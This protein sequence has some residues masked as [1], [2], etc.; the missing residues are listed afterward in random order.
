[1]ALSSVLDI[2]QSGLSAFQSALNVTSNNIA[3]ADNPNYTKQ[4]VI[5]S[6][7]GSQL[8]G[9]NY[10]GLGVN[11]GSIQRAS[12][13]LI[14]QQIRTNNGVYSNF[15]TRNDLL[16]QVQNLFG[17]PSSNGLSSLTSAFF[18]AWQAL[19]VTP[20]SITLRNNVIQAAQ[21]M[22]NQIQDINNGIQTIKSSIN[23]QLLNTVNQ[24]NSD[25]QKIHDLN[26]QI[27]SAGAT[28]GQPND[29]MDNRDQVIN[30]LSNLVN[31]NVTY[32]N[33]NAASISIGGSFA[34]DGGSYNQLQ[35][36]NS[37]GKLII[38]NSNGNSTITLN[39]G[40][41]FALQDVYNNVIPSY[42]SGLDSYVN[43]L[44]TAVNKIH[45]QGY[46][47]DN[48]P[49]T[50][51][52]FFDSYTGGVLKINSQI[53]N[54]P[55]KIAVSADGTQGN[56]D[57]AVNIANIATA[58]DSSGAT[59]QDNY[60]TLITK[61]ASDTQNASNSADSYNTI[62]QQLQNQK[63]SYAGVSTDEELTNVIKYQNAYNAAAKMIS[64]ANEMLQTLINT[65]Q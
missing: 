37:N 45:S 34:V 17:E 53:M 23:T 24:I 50:G 61:I 26:V 33:K 20:N 60:S 59:I 10:F 9:Q 62:L 43:S 27:I 16:T 49:Q 1:M 63:S 5:L 3:N 57:L 58:Q 46:T 11:L 44:M 65:V 30:D 18:N 56:G 41:A 8:L 32:D 54:N 29:L 51:E 31:I 4:Q 40:S 42:Q 7:A 36:Q 13:A 52:N 64:I 25:L 21:S 19:S 55:S 22:S 39:G 28:G 48:P 2:S 12:N 47:L 15:N 38:V 6:S 14:D 35:V